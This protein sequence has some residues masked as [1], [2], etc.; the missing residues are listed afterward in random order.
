[1][2]NSI[3]KKKM[4]SVVVPVYNTEK[5]IRECIDSIIEQDYSYFEIILV[6]DGS[7]DNSGKLCDEYAN[8]FDNVSVLHKEN[9]GL[10]SARN[11]GIDA[12]RG[13]LITF[14]DSDDFYLVKDV[15][16]KLVKIIDRYDIDIACCN[17]TSDRN[18]VYSDSRRHSEISFYKKEEA[19]SRLFDDYGIRCFSCNK[20]FKKQ[21]FNN[22]RFPEGKFFEDIITMYHVMENVK[23]LAFYDEKMYFYRKRCN[24]ITVSPFSDKNFDMLEAINHVLLNAEHDHPAAYERLKVG[25]SYYYLSYIN[26][27]YLGRIPI[28]NDEKKL[29]KHIRQNMVDIIH[30][31]GLRLVRKMMVILFS[32]SPKIYKL[33]YVPVFVFFERF[34]YEKE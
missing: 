1:M 9:G 4:V 5:Y 13:D 25:Y 27:A 23:S 22:I 33:V 34:Y 3:G 14:I 18:A 15:I 26:K 31:N 17:Y 7:T 11:A 10:S 6:D 24:S 32:I 12:A 2:T 28:Y 20:L 21:I 8:S 29:K 30:S 19:I 16:R